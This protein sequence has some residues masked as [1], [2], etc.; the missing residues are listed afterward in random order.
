MRRRCLP[1]ESDRSVFAGNIELGLLLRDRTLAEATAMHCR[2][3]I[4]DGW[5]RLA[6]ALVAVRSGSRSRGSRTFRQ[7]GFHP[8][9]LIGGEPR[10]AQGQAGQDGGADQRFAGG[11]FGEHLTPARIEAVR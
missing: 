10:P 5:L 2:K 6:T 8:R 1:V 3:L 11:E 9:R 7:A 4:E